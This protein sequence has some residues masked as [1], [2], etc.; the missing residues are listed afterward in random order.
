MTVTGADALVKK[1]RQE[2]LQK[3]LRKGLRRGQTE[4]LLRILTSRFGPLPQHVPIRIETMRLE[5]ITAMFDRVLTA[6]SLADL[7]LGH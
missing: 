3:G 7:G 1:G 6:E 5:A 2:G 4:A